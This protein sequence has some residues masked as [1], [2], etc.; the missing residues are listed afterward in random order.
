M[1]LAPGW[2]VLQ[3]CPMD[4]QVS[5]SVLVPVF[6]EEYLVA[7][8]LGR[9]RLLEEAAVL[10]DVQ[11]IVVD[12]C[13]TDRTWQALEI[14]RQAE[15][16]RPNRKMRFVFLRHQRNRGKGAAVRT[17]LASAV[18]DVSVIHDADLEYHPRDLIRMAQV[19]VS[20]E[21]DAVFGSRFAGG[22]VRRALLYRH[23]LGNRLLTT[24][25]NLVSD[26]NL[27]DMETGYKA[28][29]TELLQSLPLRSDD[30]RIEPELCIKL[31]K[32]G[33]RIFEV[34]ISYSGRTYQEGKKINWRDGF[35][36]LGAIARFGLSDD[37]Y[38]DDEYG[39][40]ILGRLSRAPRYNAW[41]A[42]EVRPHCGEQILEIGSGVGNLTRYLIPKMR[43]TVS[44]VN[45]SYLGA[46]RNLSEDRPYLSVSYCDVTDEKSFPLAQGSYDTVIC[47]NVLEHVPDDA[48]A[49]RNIHHALREHGKAIVLVPQG[50]SNFGTLDDVLG[51]RRRYTADGLANLARRCGFEVRGMVPLNRVGSAAWF[52]NG[53]VLRRK[54][55]SLLQ[56]WALNALTPVLRRVDRVLPLPPL[57][58][59]AILEKAE[60]V[61][62]RA[63]ER[64]SA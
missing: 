62:D 33:A 49:L 4:G 57:S 60:A 14:F 13:S 17:A 5:L 1:A 28:V 11:V 44:D 23:Q 37:L 29:R 63:Q 31:A 34:P 43:Y 41:I 9:L 30:F 56:I 55:F 52:L 6:N 20:E 64:H 16:A 7:E 40:Q 8:S 35:R 48:D 54:H 46:L 2:A 36:A 24:L 27:T 45:P 47:L 18:N 10:S 15:E 3:P 58:L 53:K 50:P 61:A 42:D 21:A 51:H 25:G 26:L 22:E 12:D 59:I 32:R 19:F 38:R 39:S